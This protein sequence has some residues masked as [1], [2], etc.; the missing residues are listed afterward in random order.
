MSFIID[1]MRAFIKEKIAWHEKRI[2]SSAE[3]V[4]Q[5]S[6]SAIST[7]NQV[8]VKLEDLEKQINGKAK[9]EL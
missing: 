1:E 7:Y 2:D 3:Y 4:Y 8:L 6:V 5:S 9:N